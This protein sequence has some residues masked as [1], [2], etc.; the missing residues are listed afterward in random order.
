MTKTVND[1]ALMLDVM[2]GYDKKDSTS[3]NLE[4]TNFYKNLKNKKK[5]MK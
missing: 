4:K 3:A 2:A 5:L 1:A